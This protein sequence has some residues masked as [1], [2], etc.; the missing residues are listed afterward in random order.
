MHL[1]SRH[2][3]S[4]S[5]TKSGLRLTLVLTLS[6]ALFFTD[7]ASSRS[8]GSAHKGHLVN[9]FELPIE[10]QHH[11]F[12]DPVESRKSNY[13]TLELA[14]L[15][16]RAARVV[17]SALPGGKPLMLGDC[18]VS[19]GGKIKRHVSHRSGRDV[20]MLFFRTDRGGRPTLANDFLR[21][22]GRGQCRKRGSCEERLDVPRTWWLLRTLIASQEPAVQY[23]FISR[24]IRRLLLAYAQSRGEHPELLRRA[25]RVMRQPRS[26]APH[27]DHIHLRTYCSP[28]DLKA[29]CVDHGPR[30]PWISEEGLAE[31]IA[32]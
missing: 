31:P 27:D 3:D 15:I 18:S 28:E 19:G 29:G 7:M 11:A 9:G 23:I 2:A 16:G 13:A 8:V 17:A 32:P 24:P 5:A 26:A 6:A 30:W 21:F 14:A 1:R 4:K 20:D 22:D 10:G 25:K 12:F